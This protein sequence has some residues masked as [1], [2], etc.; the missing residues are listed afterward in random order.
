[1]RRALDVRSKI[2]RPDDLTRTR[3]THRR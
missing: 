3:M 2:K 1:L